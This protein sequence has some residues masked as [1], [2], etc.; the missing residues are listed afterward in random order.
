MAFALKTTDA[1][2]AA[3]GS[4]IRAYPSFSPTA[5]QGPEF[6]GCAVTTL[7]T[8]QDPFARVRVPYA[9]ED[10]V[11]ARAAASSVHRRDPVVLLDAAQIPDDA[12]ELL[13]A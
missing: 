13:D 5:L 12:G 7:R 1:A 6:V 4:E 3:L 8:Q 10:E 2:V 9:T 11:E